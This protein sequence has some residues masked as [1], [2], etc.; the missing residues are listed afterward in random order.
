MTFAE[1]RRRAVRNTTL[2]VDRF[3]EVVTVEQTGMSPV[4]IT[5]KI[6]VDAKPAS[7]GDK[8]G[9]KRQNDSEERIRVVISHD[10][11]FEGGY[12]ADTPRIGM[13]L[14]RDESADS[15]VRPWVY[16]GECVHRTPHCGTYIF[17]RVRRQFDARR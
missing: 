10:E 14:T 12:L 7:N 13:F 6:E 16:A 9:G 11:E 3:A 4:E 8:P 2:N 5:V 15:D 1:M 17:A